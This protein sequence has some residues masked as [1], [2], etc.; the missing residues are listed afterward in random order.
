[1]PKAQPFSSMTQVTVLL[2]TNEPHAIPQGIDT[3]QENAIQP[4]TARSTGKF[5]LARF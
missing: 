2:L 5:Q 4:I 1:M 3:E